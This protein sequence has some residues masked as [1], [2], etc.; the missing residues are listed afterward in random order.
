MTFKPATWYP[1]TIALSA[2]NLVGAGLAA[3]GGETWHAGLHV[4][5]AAGFA[6]AARHV[7]RRITRN[8]SQAELQEVEVELA[9]LRQELIDA[10]ERLDF[11]ERMLAQG[12]EPRRMEAERKE[13]PITP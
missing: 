1:I 7:G 11:A 8:E 9:G 6:L 12:V 5:L 2:I 10:Q 13:P 3:G 4:V